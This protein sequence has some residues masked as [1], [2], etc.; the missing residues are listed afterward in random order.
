MKQVTVYFKVSETERKLVAEGK[1]K[2][3]SL[4]NCMEIDT[5]LELFST[6]PVRLMNE[7]KEESITYVE[8]SGGSYYIH[9]S[10]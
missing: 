8:T 6:S 4:G 1:V 9:E 7:L 5:D 10:V 3:L 2:C